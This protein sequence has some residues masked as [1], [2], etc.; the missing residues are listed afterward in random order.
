M[1]V[2]SESISP[3]A[4]QVRSLLPQA[5]P[6]GC[7]LIELYRQYFD[8]VP[9]DSP[10]LRD[11]AYRLRYQVYCVEN[12]FENPAEHLDG[13]ERDQYDEHSVHSLLIHRPTGALAG[14]VRLVLPKLGRHLPIRH[15]CDHPLLSIQ[16]KMPLNATAEISRFAVSKQFR[17]R[18]T[19]KLGVDYAL[20]EHSPSS[21]GLD[22]R[23]I[24]HITLG[25]MKAIVQMSWEHGITHWT[26]VMEPALLRL[27]R[28]LGLEFNPLGT[29]VQY[30][31]LRQPCY[32]DANVV[33][34]GMRLQNR[35]AWAL[36]TEAGEHFPCVSVE[37]PR[38]IVNS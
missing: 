33:L 16:Q 28:R 14:T 19:D 34:S 11:E 1:D 35:D 31:G 5:Q 29:A 21:S 18:A 26:A 9:A 13:R 17:R 23:L 7:G 15:V 25:L 3:E 30:H 20:V 4:T 6:N 36:I 22:R 27:I 8:V 10:K 38:E 12:P 32:G 2:L 37:V 24:P